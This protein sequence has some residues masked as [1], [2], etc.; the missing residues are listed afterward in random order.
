MDLNILEKIFEIVN[1]GKRV[2][3]VTLTKSSGSTPRKDGTLMGVWNEDFIGTIGGGLVEYRVITEARRALEENENMSFK[4][5]LIKE[6]ELGMSCGGSVEG[7]IKIINPKNRIV[8]AGAGHIGQKLYEILESSDFERVILDDREEYK[9]HFQN[10]LIGDYSELIKELP[11]NENTYFIIVTKGH[12]TDQKSLEAALKKKSKYIGMVGSRKKV[13]EIKKSIHEKGIE[14]EEEKLYSPIGLKLSDG[15]PFEIAI[16]IMAEI[17][18]VKN[19][20]ELVH[21]RL[22]NVNTF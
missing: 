12:I 9:N 3:L 16:E 18:K 19:N 10:I 15:S 14:L 4:Y 8:I 20:G 1:K 11:E 6:A 5:D 22:K 2:A 21:R 13:I 7:Y 17:L